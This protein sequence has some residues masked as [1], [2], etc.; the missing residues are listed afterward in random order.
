MPIHT[1]SPS[2]GQPQTPGS[3][4]TAG[5][6]ISADGTAR[7][8]APSAPASSWAAGARSTGR[9]TVPMCRLSNRPTIPPAT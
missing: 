9:S 3:S 8:P 1:S 2:T 5:T 7:T 6:P 4:T